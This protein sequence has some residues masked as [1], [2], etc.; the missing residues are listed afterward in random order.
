MT[1]K[2]DIAFR[3]LVREAD[4]ELVLSILMAST[5]ADQVVE[6]ATLD[7]VRNW[8]APTDRFDPQDDIL[9]VLGK[10]HENEY[11]EV[12]F[13]RVSWHTGKG[14][15][16]LYFQTSFLLPE[17]R[18]Q[19]VWP[20]M[21]VESE[22]RL[23]EIASSHPTAPKR[24]FQA[25]ATGTQHEWITVL[26][27]EGYKAVRHF[28]NMVRPLC[29]LPVREL[30]K[31]LQ[32]RPAQKDHY[33]SIWAAQKEVHAELFETVAENW[34]DD[35]YDAWTR[36][37][38]HTPELWQVAWDGDQVAGMVLPRISEAENKEL[39][40]NKGHVEHVFVRKPWRRRGL[41]GALIARSLRTLKMHGM[42]VAELGVD[43]ENESGAFGFY[44]KMG[45][46][47]ASTDIWYRKSMGPKSEWESQLGGQTAQHPPAL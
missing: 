27:K 24:F 18:G 21:V 22:R 26:E 13:S 14:G 36:D 38:S 47:T 45:F 46:Q 11:T 25:W 42:D 16:R 44:G 20:A 28:D 5:K 12:G 15:T 4:Y 7:D 32:V 31:G 17:Y 35:N 6:T 1:K 10:S 34:T 2:P 9:I 23:L 29:D 40:R 39:G 30:P 19:G 41:A 43:T 3:K 8:C 33:R 37:S